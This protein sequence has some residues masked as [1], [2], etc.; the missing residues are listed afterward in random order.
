[1]KDLE[2]RADAGV[3]A[4]VKSQASHEYRLHLL[5]ISAAETEAQLVANAAMYDTWQRFPGNSTVTWLFTRAM[6]SGR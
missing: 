2:R 1:M 3:I 4:S 5:R 6:R